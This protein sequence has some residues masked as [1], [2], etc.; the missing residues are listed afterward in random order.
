MKTLKKT[1]DEKLMHAGHRARMLE[2]FEKGGLAGFSEVQ[3]VE[4]FLTYIFPRGDVNPLAHRL[5]NRFNN[6]ASILDADI[7]DLQS[8]KGIGK[9]AAVAIHGWAVLTQEYLMSAISEKEFLGTHTRLYDFVE[10]LLRMEKEECFYMIGMNASFH[11]CGFRCLARGNLTKVGIKNSE[12]TK[13]LNS[14][15]PVFVVMAHNHPGGKCLASEQDYTATE[16][17]S[18]LLIRLEKTYVDHLIVG[19]D[20]IFSVKNKEVCREFKPL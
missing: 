13:F 8:V 2:C 17:L 14:V 12:V 16:H 19:I 10:N 5:L 4:F 18:D 20:G 7:A 6:F 3:V 11:L 1:D 9:R 15:D